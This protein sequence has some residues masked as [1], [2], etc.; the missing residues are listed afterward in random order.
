MQEI[1][2]LKKEKETDSIY[3]FWFAT[4]KPIHFIAGQYFEL[5]LPHEKPDN[6]GEKRWFTISSSP[7]DKNISI[8]T[9]ISSKSST[10][11]Q[12]LLNLKKGSL[13]KMAPPMGD[14]VLPKNSNKPL[15]FVAGG[16]G[17][18]PFHSMLSYL[19]KS[20]QKRDIKML[21]AVKN[22]K[23]IIWKDLFKKNTT[24]LSM[25]VSNPLRTKNSKLTS[26]DILKH[27][28]DKNRLIYLSG[29]EPMVEE[30]NDE[31]IASGIREQDINTDFFAGY[32]SI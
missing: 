32:K 15:L 2:F 23:D 9:R 22:D 5:Y 8:T 20:N 16:I 29:P 27:A 14:F 31:L 12:N 11:K 18:T 7:T 26:N 3:T 10:F 21:Y 6:R 28:N 24:E 1:K 13:Y 30:I 25:F 4:N 17:C 19:K